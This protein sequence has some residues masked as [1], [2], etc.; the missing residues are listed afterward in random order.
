MQLFSEFRPSDAGSGRATLQYPSDFGI[1][2]LEV[3]TEG[4][5]CAEG[6]FHVQVLGSPYWI[7]VQILCATLVT[8]VDLIA[9]AAS[10]DETAARLWLLLAVP[11]LVLMAVDLGGRWAR[12][13]A[14]PA[15][16]APNRQPSA[17][18]KNS[19]QHISR[20]SDAGISAHQRTDSN[21][22]PCL[23]SVAPVADVL[24]SIDRH[25][26]AV[27]H[28][29]RSSVNHAAI[30]RDPPASCTGR[31]VTDSA[32]VESQHALSAHNAPGLS[33]AWDTGGTNR[34]SGPS[35]KGDCAVRAPPAPAGRELRGLSPTT[36][37]AAD[38][39]S[40]CGPAVGVALLAW[41]R[42]FAAEHGGGDVGD[43][44]A[45]LE[46]V[47]RVWLLAGALLLPLAALKVLVVY[48]H[49]RVVRAQG[50][51]MSMQM[52]V[53]VMRTAQGS[54]WTGLASV[55]AV[56]VLLQAVFQGLSDARYV[57]DNA[58]GLLASLARAAPADLERFAAASAPSWRDRTG[59]AI[60]AVWSGARV[61]W[62]A[63]PASNAP[64]PTTTLPGTAPSLAAAIDWDGAFAYH[65]ERSVHVRLVAFVAAA[66][67]VALSTVA[68]ANVVC[69]PF[70]SLVARF[71]EA[72]RSVD[73]ETRRSEVA[74]S[75]PNAVLD[76]ALQTMV[77]L[78]HQQ[79]G[80]AAVIGRLKESLPRPGDVS[81]WATVL[82]GREQAMLPP[83][84]R[85]RPARGSLL[86]QHSRIIA[87]LAGAAPAASKA[88]HLVK[89][90][91]VDWDPLELDADSLRESVV[92]MF[93]RLRLL[94]PERDGAGAQET[95]ERM[96]AS[97]LISVVRLEALIDHLA[98]LYD[99]GND[100]HNWRHAV[101][102]THTLFTII[103]TTPVLQRRLT[104]LD[105]L[106][107]MVAAL[108][109]DVCHSGTNNQFL[110]DTNAPVAL[111]YN[112]RSVQENM[113]AATL[114]QLMANNPEA[115][116]FADLPRKT[117]AAVRR[118]V[119]GAIL[120]TDMAR[121]F[122]LVARLEAAVET[123]RRGAR[124]AEHE[125]QEHAL[126]I[127]SLMHLAD[128][129]HSFKPFDDTCEWTQRLMQEFFRQGD[130][131]REIGMQPSPLMQRESLYVPAAQLDFYQVVL[132][133]Y[134]AAM[135]RLVPGLSRLLHVLQRN[136]ELWAGI[137]E[138]DQRAAR[139]AQ[140]QGISRIECDSV[141]GSPSGSERVFAGNMAMTSQYFTPAAINDNVAEEVQKI[142]VENRKAHV[143]R[144]V[145]DCLGITS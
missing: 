42:G 41:I 130:M 101:D 64:F 133:P 25:R 142:D 57:A 80:G 35:D 132:L 91:S 71:L 14:A 104:R 102:V 30:H 69:A 75:D 115:N 2:G 84:S 19:L 67:L 24:Q 45:A 99:T 127:E 62:L 76:R 7:S 34:F 117:A 135:V 63:D 68:A 83:P 78:S 134:T 46:T 122:D 6:H 77:A 48:W 120:A 125:A 85:G 37:L 3:F 89:I 40:V 90:D 109:H 20:T 29:P 114:F 113:H 66:S 15:P 1:G 108:G 36:A 8:F 105:R 16:A 59:D 17:R 82:V 39:L 92:E 58:N 11:P 12:A 26:A 110:I 33:V 28:Q 43:L 141:L 87:G 5:A 22:P 21:M 93:R 136:F 65:L 49:G 138:H 107:L 72:A 143:R 123:R 38:T 100:Y 4:K 44:R 112:D 131:E 60:G 47:H 23:P 70:Q 96:A 51:S 140:E 32:L 54:L 98:P 129:G 50:P 52:R 73:S 27:L 10:E 116:V 13:K 81:E 95:A 31:R 128:L 111:A 18:P 139:A 88:P 144:V 9:F 61:L 97:G 79:Q 126:I 118:T 137:V 124:S 74:C 103:L 86:G 119:V 94:Y 56:L 53:V 55:L 121:H 145:E 106:A